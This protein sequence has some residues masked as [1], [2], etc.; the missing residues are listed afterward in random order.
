MLPGTALMR[1]PHSSS[2]TLISTIPYAV[3]LKS[4]EWYRRLYIV[5]RCSQKS[6]HFEIKT[7]T[8][9]VDILKSYKISN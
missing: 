3:Q 8:K 2:H 9:I 1:S 5:F 4:I 6:L 7:S